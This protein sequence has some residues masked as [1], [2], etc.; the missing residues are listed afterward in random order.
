MTHDVF[1][2][3]R[4][5]ERTDGRAGLFDDVRLHQIVLDDASV[6]HAA[7]FVRRVRVRHDGRHALPVRVHA[8]DGEQIAAR[9]REVFH[10]RP[11]RVPRR[12]G[13]QHKP[14]S[15]T[16]RPAARTERLLTTTRTYR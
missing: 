8:G 14:G 11:E 6:V 10:R 16:A 13:Q 5:R 1:Q 12:P 3:T 4:H 7:R 9:D 15:L 2:G